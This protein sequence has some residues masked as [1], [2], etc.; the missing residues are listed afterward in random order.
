[1]SFQPVLPVGGYAGWRFLSRT[2]Q[3]QQEAFAASPAVT[4]PADH[5]RERIASVGSAGDLVAD[6]QLLR[7]ALGAF[8]LD[9]DL[10]SRAFIRAVLEGGT[11]QGDS[12]ANRLSDKRYAAFSAAMGFGDL[13]GA[14]RTRQ[15]GFAEEIVARY[16]ARQF[17]RAV[18]AQDDTLRRALNVQ[19]ALTEIVDRATTPRAQ[20]FSIMG[21]PPLRSVIETALGLPASFGRLDID[22]QLAGFQERSRRVL[23]TDD[24]AALLEPERKETLIRLYMVR[25]E[26][27]LGPRATGASIALTLLRAGQPG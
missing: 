14:G 11:T 4:R 10:D 24:P 23:G 1:M 9:A 27:A 2:L 6:R 20:W 8:G 22:Q 25:S 7:V 15:E 26:A 12:L 16:E 13:G 21:D 19:T 17:Q 18:G 5:F 3:T